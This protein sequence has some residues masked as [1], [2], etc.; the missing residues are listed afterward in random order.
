M[1]KIARKN[2]KLVGAIAKR[3][4]IVIIL[5]FLGVTVRAVF[6]S[7][8]VKNECFFSCEQGPTD[9]HSGICTDTSRFECITYTA[10]MSLGSLIYVLVPLIYLLLGFVLI[11]KI[12]KSKYWL[13]GK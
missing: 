3:F 4:F 10:I 8:A 12:V 13:K 9:V 1:N 11:I 2:T 6:E 7:L 5:I